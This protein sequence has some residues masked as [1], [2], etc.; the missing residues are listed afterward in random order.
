MYKLLKSCFGSC[1]ALGSWPRR[2]SIIYQSIQ[3]M[4]IAR[5]VDMYTIRCT[6]IH[7]LSKSSRWRCVQM[8]CLTKFGLARSYQPHFV[9]QPCRENCRARVYLSKEVLWGFGWADFCCHLKHSSIARRQYFASTN[10]IIYYG[11]LIVYWYMSKC[12]AW[13]SK[14]LRS[15]VARGG[16]DAIHDAQ[17]VELVLLLKCHFRAASFE[18]LQLVTP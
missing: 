16:S 4:N 7:K 1:N 8:I 18:N 10:G 11:T 9:K 13:T 17:W 2:H 5:C 15:N 6:Y 14:N 12:H 3:F